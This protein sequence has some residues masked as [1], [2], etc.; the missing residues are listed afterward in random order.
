MTTLRQIKD[1]ASRAEA[2]LLQ[3]AAGAAALTVM[4]VVALHLPSLV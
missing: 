4:L 2:T 1:I 3:D